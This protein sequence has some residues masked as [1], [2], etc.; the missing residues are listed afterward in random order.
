MSLTVNKPPLPPRPACVMGITL[1]YMCFCYFIFVNGINM[2]ENIN[3]GAERDFLYH[4]C[5]P[6]A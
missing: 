6:K 4:W 5:V 2:Y 3:P 1:T